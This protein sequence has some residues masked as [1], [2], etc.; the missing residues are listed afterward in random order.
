M[1]GIILAAG[2]GTRLF[3]VSE[4]ISKILLPVYDKPMVYYPLATLMQAGIREILI[5]TNSIDADNFKRLLGNGS[6]FGLDISYAVQ[7]VQRGIADAFIIGEEFIGGEDVCLI[8]GDNIFHHNDIQNLLLNAVADNKGATVFGYAVPDPERFGVVEFDQ[9]GNVIS[10]EEKPSEP[11]TNYAVVGLYFYDGKVCEIAKGLKPSARG[12]LEIT[13]LNKEYL[14]RGMLRCVMFE[15]DLLWMDA[16]T[17][18]S[19]HDAGSTVRS[20]QKDLGRPIA[21]PEAIALSSGYVSSDSMTKWVSAK[22]MN[23]YYQHVR[24]MCE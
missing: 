8:L 11:K 2:N 22:K 16:G 5:I 24:R 7:H 3:P 12:E 14:K 19:L 1:K 9:D 4:P 17:F 15:K 10:L 18:D 13:D 20:I 21:C 6:Q 23:E